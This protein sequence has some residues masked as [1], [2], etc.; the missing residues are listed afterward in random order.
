[1][2]L[3]MLNGNSTVLLPQ[4]CR[5]K[6]TVSS[7]LRSSSPLTFVTAW[8]SRRR[9]M[10]PYCTKSTGVGSALG[11]TTGIGFAVAVWL[12]RISIVLR[13]TS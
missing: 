12:G 2:L 10:L 8:R 6:S 3:R 13:A 11:V 4:D 5:S 9:V 1:M 7:E